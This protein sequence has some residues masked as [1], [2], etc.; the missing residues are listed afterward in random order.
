MLPKALL[1]GA[2]GKLPLNILGLLGIYLKVF[3][4]SHF[5]LPTINELSNFWMR[6]RLNSFMNF[7]KSVMSKSGRRQVLSIDI[8]PAPDL[9]CKQGFKAV[10]DVIR[11]RHWSNTVADGFPRPMFPLSEKLLNSPDVGTSDCDILYA[12]SKST[13]SSEQVL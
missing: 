2:L 6:I 13:F 1:C 3:P 8:F 5:T 9:Y 10:V 7:C 12:L 4:F 11:A